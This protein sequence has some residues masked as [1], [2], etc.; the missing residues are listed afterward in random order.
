MN[1]PQAPVEGSHLWTLQ[2]HAAST[3]IPTRC[4]A[5]AIARVSHSPCSSHACLNRWR[6]ARAFSSSPFRITFFCAL[7]H[8][9]SRYFCSLHAPVSRPQYPTSSWHCLKA[10]ILSTHSGLLCS[11]SVGC[12]RP[13]P[14]NKRRKGRQAAVL[15][16]PKSLDRA[17]LRARFFN[18]EGVKDR[19]CF[20]IS[21]ADRTHA[22]TGVSGSQIGFHYVH[23]TIRTNMGSFASWAL[24]VGADCS[25]PRPTTWSHWP[26]GRVCQ[27]TVLPMLARWAI[28]L[29]LVIW[30]RHSIYIVAVPSCNARHR[31]SS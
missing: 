2:R 15:P 1:M 19:P 28:Y 18:L 31:P 3:T 9:S 12:M 26:E 10:N 6:S 13:G 21:T 4:G 24:A 20:P 16:S 27:R 7:K 30:R 8:F 17:C 29:S 5:A 22:R 23:D 14:A 25:W 11:D